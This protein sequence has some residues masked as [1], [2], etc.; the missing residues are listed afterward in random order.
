[1]ASRLVE[2]L[3]REHEE[4][5]EILIAVKSFGIGT[6]EGR[7]KLLS[8]KAKLLSHLKKEDEKLYPALNRAAQTDARLKAT[9][10]TFTSDM[11]ETSKKALEF[12]GKYEKGEVSGLEFARDSGRLM[13]ILKTRIQK[14]ERALYPEYDKLNP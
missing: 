8:A 14:E 2:E 4:I 7:D 6:K 9:L 10:D 12:F 11:Q 5:A 3:K 13:G 1:M